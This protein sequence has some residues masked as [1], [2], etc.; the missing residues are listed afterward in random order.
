MFFCQISAAPTAIGY[1]EPPGLADINVRLAGLGPAH[2]GMVSN[3]KVPIKNTTTKLISFFFII[4]TSIQFLALIELFGTTFFSSF[5]LYSSKF[6][7]V[8]LKKLFMLVV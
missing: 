3:S 8:C 1:H 4:H 7:R 6:I 2:A 5:V